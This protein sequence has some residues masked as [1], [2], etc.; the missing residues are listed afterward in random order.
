MDAVC[1]DKA[2][3]SVIFIVLNR[4]KSTAADDEYGGSRTCTNSRI[5]R[6]DTNLCQ[7]GTHHSSKAFAVRKH[8][9]PITDLKLGAQEPLISSVKINVKCLNADLS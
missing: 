9:H 6:G 8:R 2:T 5:G 7:K 4:F 1:V 3:H